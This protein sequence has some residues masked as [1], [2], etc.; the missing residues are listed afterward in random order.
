MWT[1][2]KAEHEH[3][4]LLT[5]SSNSSG[6]KRGQRR[7]WHQGQ[8]EDINHLPEGGYWFGPGPVASARNGEKRSVVSFYA[9]TI[10]PDTLLKLRYPETR[11]TEKILLGGGSS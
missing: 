10:Q 7:R 3:P 8:D 11:T 4:A 9:H 6:G 2:G 1:E 5:Q